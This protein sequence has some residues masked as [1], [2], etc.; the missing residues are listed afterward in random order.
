MKKQNIVIIDYEAGNLQSVKYAL[1]RLGVNAEVSNC[2]KTIRQADKVIFPGVGEAAWAMKKLRET[3]LDQLIPQLKQP[4]L[5]ICLG[6]QLMCARSEEGDTKGLGLFPVDALK[7]PAEDKVPHM[8]WNQIKQLKGKLFEGIKA[9]SYVYFVHS[10]YVPLNAYTRAETDYIKAFS[11][12]L[13]KD[14]FYAC[15]FHPEKSGDI[16]QAILKNFIKL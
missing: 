5:G 6:M 4:V 12:S 10:Y 9:E 8:G 1:E 7:F 11:A 13:Q 14:N 15:Q 3:G 2:E 16:G